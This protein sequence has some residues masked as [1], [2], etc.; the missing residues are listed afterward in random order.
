MAQATENVIVL[1]LSGPAWT[2]GHI[3]GT[4]Q[5][6]E[7][8][9][10][11]W[12]VKGVANFLRNVDLEG[13]ASVCEANGVAGPDFFDLGVSSF[14]ADLRLTPFAAKKVVAARDGFLSRL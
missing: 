7:E 1:R 11:S 14:H 12:C 3:E 4:P 6:P 13:P 5:T 8:E 9:M 2:G 10:K